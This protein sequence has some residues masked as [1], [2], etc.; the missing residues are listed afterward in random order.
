M[1]FFSSQKKE[2]SAIIIFLSSGQIE[3]GFFS[4]GS[5]K[6]TPDI[7]VKENFKF[8]QNINSEILEQE[9]FY[10]L[11]RVLEKVFKEISNKNYNKNN[12]K[13]YF[14]LGSMWY[15]STLI[16]I[17]IKKNKPF[18]AEKEEIIKELESKS[19]E[20][21]SNYGV[22]ESRVISISANGYEIK[23]LKGKRANQVSAKAII[24]ISEKRIL[25]KIVDETTKFFPEAKI[26]INTLPS[27]SA[28]EISHEISMSDYLLVVSEEEITELCFIKKGQSIES[29]SVPFGKNLFIRKIIEKGFAKDSNHADSILKMYEE[30]SLE[31]TKK[32]TLEQ[33]INEQIGNCLKTLKEVLFQYFSKNERPKAIVI[34]SSS[35]ETNLILKNIFSDSYI[36]NGKEGDF[37]KIL[38]SKNSKQGISFFTAISGI[39]NLYF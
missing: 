30:N 10:T 34:L 22:I 11:N 23:N 31:K 36:H 20:K 16:N 19:L 12:L 17:D 32:E 8:I 27:I 2:S 21:N 33:I 9:T 13:I 37:V 24:N 4:L 7:F 6:K 14:V 35:K 15:I 5:I 25:H 29:F 3:A 28:N 1:T 38:L 39:Q 26:K 18:F